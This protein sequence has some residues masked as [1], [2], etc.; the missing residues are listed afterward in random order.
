MIFNDPMR[1]KQILFNAIG[2]SNKFTKEGNITITIS[3][4]Q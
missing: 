1:L 4:Y 3:Q 2:N